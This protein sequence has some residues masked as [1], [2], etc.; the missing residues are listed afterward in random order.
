MP[1]SP[2]GSRAAAGQYQSIRRE[3]HDA[4]RLPT[5]AL[6]GRQHQSRGQ[7]RIAIGRRRGRNRHAP[8]SRVCR[9][10]RWR[11]LRRRGLGCQIF[12]HDR[13][14]HGLDEILHVRCDCGCSGGG[15]H[16]VLSASVGVIPRICGITRVMW[17]NAVPAVA[18]RHETP[19]GLHLPP[20]CRG[21]AY[22]RPSLADR[23][24]R[25]GVCLS[26]CPIAVQ[27]ARFGLCSR[28][29][30]P[31]WLGDHRRFATPRTPTQV[32]YAASLS[33]LASPARRLPMPSSLPGAQALRPSGSPPPMQQ[34][35]TRRRSL[36]GCVLH[37]IE[38]S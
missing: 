5:R 11:P 8:A 31:C 20:V 1:W 2:T 37:P 13:A 6:C 33:R 23:E 19:A 7:A 25:F 16:A 28:A 29:M 10:G 4:R 32:H 34:R 9:L 3:R 26:A 38:R 15:C 12:V 18:A 27:A 24:T 14:G 17:R 35:S 36:A 22:S 30:L 21:L